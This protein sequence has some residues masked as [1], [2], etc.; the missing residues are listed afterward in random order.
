M[1]VAIR[2]TA[3]Y[4]EIA[5]HEVPDSMPMPMPGDLVAYVP[6][7]AK[8]E[9]FVLRQVKTRVFNFLSGQMMFVVD[10]VKE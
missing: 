4:G 8:P 6:A 7:G 9:D 1:K 2:M 10:H 3:T 5:R